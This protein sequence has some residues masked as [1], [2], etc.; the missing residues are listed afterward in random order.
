MAS[1]HKVSLSA[2]VCRNSSFEELTSDIE[3]LIDQLCEAEIETDTATDVESV[4]RAITRERRL[5]FNLKMLENVRSEK[6]LARHM[7]SVVNE[8]QASTSLQLRK[9]ECQLSSLAIKV[10]A[11]CE[12]S[13]QVHSLQEE[14][15][16]VNEVVYK[17]ERSRKDVI[18]S[19]AN[20]TKGHEELQ[21]TVDTIDNRQRSRN[22]VLYGLSGEHP[23]RQVK[24]LLD[25]HRPL[26][27]SLET[28][29][30]I[31]KG[32][33]RPTLLWFQ[34][35][36]S[37]EAFLC[38]TRTKRFREE[39]PRLSAANDERVRTRVGAS[40][41]AAAAP[42]LKKHFAGITIQRNQVRYK[43]ETYTAADFSS[44]TIKIDQTVF[45]ITAAAQRNEDFE[46]SSTSV[47][48]AL[49][50]VPGTRFRE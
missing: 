49:D 47:F 8:V 2:H 34:T 28:A 38:V 7:A 40:R 13:D 22:A 43:G 26:L 24:K 5:R 9:L 45:D 10:D 1:H 18:R 35:M 14:L 29:H 30:Y 21:R 32:R 11:H 37:K 33:S 6:V 42:V 23:E 46:P 19:V 12:I 15:D 50:N 4:R 39:N 41:L 36:S 27:K 31:G 25:A 3:I 44:Q 48:A 20:L 16:E 17:S